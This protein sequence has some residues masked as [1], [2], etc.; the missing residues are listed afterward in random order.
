MKDPYLD[1]L[2]EVWYDIVTLYQEFEDKKP[3]ML[4]NLEER[5]LYAYPYLDYKKD[6]SESSQALLEKQYTRAL[7]TGKMVVFV[8]DDAK[9]RLRSYL[10]YCPSNKASST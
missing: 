8:R 6:L 7:K 9:K 4:F 1:S 3:V 2:R 10:F 5:K